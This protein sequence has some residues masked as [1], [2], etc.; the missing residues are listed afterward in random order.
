M[1]FFGGGVSQNTRSLDPR[2]GVHGKNFK[3]CLLGGVD[4]GGN[5]DV[6]TLIRRTSAT[7]GFSTI[8]V[9]TGPAITITAFG[10]GTSQTQ[11]DNDPSREA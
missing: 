11:V 5:V 10:G 4:G 8:T 3:S 1:T 2:S 6:G 9:G 7:R